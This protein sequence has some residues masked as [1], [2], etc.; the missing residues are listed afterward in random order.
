M[1]KILYMIAV[2]LLMCGGCNETS[3]S[4]IAVNKDTTA[5]YDTILEN[6]S[7][8]QYHVEIANSDNLSAELI[9]LYDSIYKDNPI[10]I[11]GAERDLDTTVN[12]YRFIFRTGK[13][14]LGE[15]D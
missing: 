1:K 4:Y 11:R 13:N 6:K 10:I 2:L 12:H 3:S 8:I 7:V 15:S 9:K 5:N 14:M